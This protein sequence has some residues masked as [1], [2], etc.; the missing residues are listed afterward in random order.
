MDQ[1]WWFPAIAPLPGKAPAVM[2]AERSL[3][4]CLIVDQNGRRFANE[5]TDYMSFGQWR[6]GG[7]PPRLIHQ[8]DAGAEFL[9][10]ADAVAGVGRSA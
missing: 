4:G 3:P 1:A 5:A 6:D 10:R 7:E 2:L 8:V 9:A